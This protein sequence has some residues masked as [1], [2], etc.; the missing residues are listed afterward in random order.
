M[1]RGR[2]IKVNILFMLLTVLMPVLQQELYI[3]GTRNLIFFFISCRDFE[4][5]ELE[6]PNKVT[7]FA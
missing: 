7:F 4:I 3:K 2:N 1:A 5:I 6:T